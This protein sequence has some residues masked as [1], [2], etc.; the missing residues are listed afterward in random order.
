[1]QTKQLLDALCPFLIKQPKKDLQRFA[2]HICRVHSGKSFRVKFIE[3]TK[4]H[5]DDI[6]VQINL[7]GA[8]HITFDIFGVF[9]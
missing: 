5:Y 9:A 8:L 2:L 7:E 1:M 6:L 4:R 3:N